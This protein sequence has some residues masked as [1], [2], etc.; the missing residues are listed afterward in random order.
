M[1]P[2]YT[3]LTTQAECAAAAADVA[4][5]LKTYSYRDTGLDLADDRA[6]RSQAAALAKKDAEITVAQS[7][8]TTAGLTPEQRQ[9]ALDT[10]ELLQA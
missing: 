2:D 10:L 6:G 8:T 7:Q 3:L 4:Y 5:E 1:N 9:D